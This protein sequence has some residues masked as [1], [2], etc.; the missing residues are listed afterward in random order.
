MSGSKSPGPGDPVGDEECWIRELTNTDYV[1]R[2]GTVHRQALKK[3]LEPSSLAGWSHEMSGRLLSL[4]NDVVAR[5][6]ASAER[7]RERFREQGKSA[8]SKIAFVGVACAT[9]GKLRGLLPGVVVTDV[10]FTPIDQDDPAHADFVAADLTSDD[11]VEQVQDAL[12]ENLRVLR[13]SDL[14][15]PRI[16]ADEAPDV[17]A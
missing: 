15:G 1:T 3:K 2:D 7:Q 11:K 12:L 9:A 17:E 14:P 8:P 16:P 13:V 5:G 4:A 6:E 10:V